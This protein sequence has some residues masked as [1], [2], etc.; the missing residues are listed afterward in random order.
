MPEVEFKSGELTLEGYLEL[1][2]GNAPFPASIVCH[3]HSL[4]GGEM[5]N[6]VVIGVCTNLVK[7][8]I[9]ALRFNFRGV[10]RSEG[11]YGDGIKEQEDT[12]AALE[13]L[14]QRKEI[15]A[16]RITLTGYSFGAYVG[17][18][19]LHNN[20]KIK[21]LIGIS[22]PLK[23]FEF[24]YLKTCKKPKLLII[25]DI[26]QFTPEKMFKNFYEELP[27][28]KEKRILQGADH[29]YWGYENEVGKITAQFLQKTLQETTP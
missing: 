12:K 9:A 4:Y 8:Q 10:G 3:P 25:G 13:F 2:K 14:L 21:A 18:A 28:P 11:E 22:P 17:L 7:N 23:L 20:E 6:N 5:H 16:N 27:Q 29:F 15:A 19:A 26:D 24:N 1:P